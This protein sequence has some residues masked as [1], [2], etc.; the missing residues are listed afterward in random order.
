[1]NFPFEN[2]TRHIE[3]K[4]AV[5]SIQADRRS[6]A[7]LFFTIALSV[8]IV[9]SILLISKGVEEKY[10]NTQRNKAQIAILGVTDDQSKRLRQNP[11]VLWVG[12]Y[13]AIG[14]FYTGDKTITVSYGNEDYFLHQEELTLEGTVPQQPDEILLPR[15]YLDF[16]G[17]NL[18]PGDT[19]SLDVTGTGQEAVYTLSGILND[20]RES[21][22]YFLYLSKELTRNLSG[23]LF[24]VTAYTRLATD[25]IR[26]PVLLDTARQVIQGTG[27][28]EEQINLTEYF[29]VMSGTIKK[30]ISLPVP[31]LAALTA[32]LAATIVYGVFYTKIVKNVQM[33]GQLRTIG[34]T[35]KQLKRMAGKEGRRYA[36]MGIPLG[37][38]SGGMIGFLGCPEGFLVKTAIRYALL[39]AVASFATVT[40]AIFKPVRV[41]MNT[42]PIEGAKYLTYTGKV[43]HRSRAHRKL[44]PFRLADINLQRN[45]QKAVLTLLMLGVSGALLLVTSTLARSI[46]PEKQAAFKYYPAGTILVGIKNT[47]GSSFDSD[48]EPFGSARLQ[49]EHNPLKDQPLL[50]ALEQIP[51]I[52][53]IT[54]FNGISMTIT[55]PAGNG[56][57]TSITD[58]FPTLTQE[59]LEEKQAVLSSGIADYQEMV[60]RNGILVAEGVAQTGDTLKIEGRAF[61]G[62]T[63]QVDAVVVGTYSRATLMEKSPVVPGSPYFMLT[64]DTAKK[65]TGITEQTG[66]L[67]VLP[68]E[69][70]FEEVLNAVEELA[71]NDG[72]LEVNT[73]KQTIHNIQY[74]YSASIKALYLTS[75]ILFVFGSISLMNMLMVDFQNRKREFGL[76]AAVGTTRKQLQNMLGW[77]IAGY[78]LGSLGIS[79][80]GGSLF[81]FLACHYLDSRNHCIT[82]RLPWLFLLALLA[83]MVM[84]DLLFTVYAKAELKKTNILSAIKAE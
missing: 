56:S 22:G 63:F 9:F 65:L 21:N 31:L 47:V 37:L 32:F 52:Q 19:I 10:K 64:Y 16:L 14:L 79:L 1:M 12:E 30:G 5:R 17:K 76:L 6:T 23:N 73:I 66:V 61:D 50:H 27:I 35:Q 13:S 48:A 84:I 44:T 62:T 15:N 4:L 18:H 42:S 39:I 20:T 43:K 36:F 54:A 78:L 70:C 2:D 59:Q 71:D 49:L 57:I 33:F 3:K 82:L 8:C 41:A 11:E 81:S 29:A 72:R 77:E 67:A 69:G 55:F 45:R 68:A 51:G 83:V 40:I 60:E 34:M 46:D 28:V 25:A 58:V 24:Q 38:L 74:R 7:F 80:T 53:K 26:S 75:G